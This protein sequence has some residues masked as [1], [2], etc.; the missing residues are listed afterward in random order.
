MITGGGWDK[1]EFKNK[2]PWDEITNR[3]CR[4]S[5]S[6][7]LLPPICVLLDMEFLFIILRHHVA[8]EQVNY[9]VRIFGIVWRV[10]DH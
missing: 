9:P 7:V 4:P 1:L 6:F 2:F 5:N 3:F 10:G 8:V